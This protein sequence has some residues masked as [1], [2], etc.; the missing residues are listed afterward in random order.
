MM[1]RR[2]ELDE[3]IATYNFVDFGDG[4][5]EESIRELETEMGLKLPP[6][7]RW[8]L[9][10]YSGGEIGGEEI[11]SIYENA[12]LQV[13]SGDFRV[14]NKNSGLKSGEYLISHDDIDGIFYFDSSMSDAHGEWP[15]ISGAV[16]GVYSVDFV[17]F[18]IKRINAHSS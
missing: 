8:W 9:L 13:F 16:G 18:L 5:A 6:S 1:S 17:G 10:K 2:S 3:L 4:V 15:V 12:N 14:A 11:F 7:F